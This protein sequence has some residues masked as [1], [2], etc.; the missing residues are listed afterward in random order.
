M[1]KHKYIRWQ[2]VKANEL[3]RTDIR[4]NEV[5]APEIIQTESRRDDIMKEWNEIEGVRAPDFETKSCTGMEK[6]DTR[7]DKILGIPSNEIWDIRY[8]IWGGKKVNDCLIWDLR[9]ACQRWLKMGF[10]W[11]KLGMRLDWM[12]HSGLKWDQTAWDHLRRDKGVWG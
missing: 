12:T 4:W 10:N 6:H 8:T 1:E 9:R 5:R 3:R 7:R 11:I 2:N